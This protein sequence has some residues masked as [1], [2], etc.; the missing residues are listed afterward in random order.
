MICFCLL[1]EF[2]FTLH[3]IQRL[4][5]FFLFLLFRILRTFGF[6]LDGIINITPSPQS[7]VGVSLSA[8][9]VLKLFGFFFQMFKSSVSFSHVSQLPYI[10]FVTRSFVIS[11]SVNLFLFRFCAFTWKIF[12]YLLLFRNNFVKASKLTWGLGLVS[13]SPLDL[14]LRSEYEVQRVFRFS[15]ALAVVHTS[16]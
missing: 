7:L 11:S 15:S 14:S 1:E 8:R 3:S 12:K 6:T 16:N 9:K 4:S 2:L 13:T 10:G 5:K